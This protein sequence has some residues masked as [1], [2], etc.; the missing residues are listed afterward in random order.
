MRLYE[1]VDYN[2][3]LTSIQK[4]LVKKK[5]T[6]RFP[7]NSEIIEILKEKDVYSIQSRNRMYLLERLENFENREYVDIE[8]N[9]D[10]T[11]EHIFP[12]NPDSKWKYDL[13]DSQ[14]NDFKEKYLNTLANLTLSGNNGSLGNKPFIEKRDL[15]EKGYKDSRLFLNKYLATLEK[16]DL[17]ELK[18][19]RDMLT[20]RFLRIWKYPNV[21]I[22][23]LSNNEEVNIFEADEP[24]HKKLE[25]VIFFE[26]KQQ[27]SKISDLYVNVI[28]FLFNE[29]PQMFFITDLGER[30]GLTKDKNTLRQ[31]VSINE[32]YYIESNLDS[33]GKFER[34]KYALT[35]AGITDEL[36]IKYS[37]N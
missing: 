5:S 31:A 35:K 19:R 25:Y 29:Q 22:D 32:T 26:Q 12:Q 36:F 11:V 4:S 3:Y 34:I 18:S 10:I 21:V 13:D 2:D 8:G 28:S 15:P 30:L 1:D 20:K 16:W 7:K 24:T 9:S 27:I 14:Y 33:R 23:D 17:G 6:Q 37:E